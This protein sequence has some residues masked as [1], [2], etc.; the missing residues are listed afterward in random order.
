MLFIYVS[1]Y[2]MYPLDLINSI[3][4]KFFIP[5]PLLEKLIVS[6]QITIGQDFSKSIDFKI[7][8]ST[9]SASI[10]KKSGNT[11]YVYFVRIPFNVSTFIF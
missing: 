1:A 10:V 2:K 9:P 6:T 3:N 8:S 4:G 7:N 5:L 11:P